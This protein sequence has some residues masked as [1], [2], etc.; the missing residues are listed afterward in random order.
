MT[1]LS[2]NYVLLKWPRLLKGALQVYISTCSKRS[3]SLT[4][5]SSRWR[6]LHTGELCAAARLGHLRVGVLRHHHALLRHVRLRVRRHVQQHHDGVGA[7][8]IPGSGGSG[9]QDGGAGRPCQRPP[10]GEHVG[11]VAPR[12]PGH[13]RGWP[14]DQSQ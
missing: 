1:L 12:D 5:L 3:L 7:R 8:R 10:I 13:H 14:L 6:V 4:P 11:A 2:Y 9:T